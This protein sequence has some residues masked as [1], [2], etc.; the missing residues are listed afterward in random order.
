[1]V[2]YCV[3]SG[4]SVIKRVSGIQWDLNPD[5]YGCAL[6]YKWC[7]KFKRPTKATVLELGDL[8]QGGPYLKASKGVHI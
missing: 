1:M 6:A 5:P 4:V 3:F 8:V 7:P 2:F